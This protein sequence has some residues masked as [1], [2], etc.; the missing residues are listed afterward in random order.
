MVESVFSRIFAL[1]RLIFQ[2]CLQ[3]I[4]ASIDTQAGKSRIVYEEA[5]E[6][7]VE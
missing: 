1:L 3:R 5:L 6:Q 4:K 2:V 7:L